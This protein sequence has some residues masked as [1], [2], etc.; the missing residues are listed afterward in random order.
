MAASVSLSKLAKKKA[1]YVDT[2]ARVVNLSEGR[3]RKVNVPL[4]DVFKTLGE[5]KILKEIYLQNTY[6]D[7][8]MILVLATE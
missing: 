6:R 2:K 3:T 4:R 8:L 7:G 1:I 5:S